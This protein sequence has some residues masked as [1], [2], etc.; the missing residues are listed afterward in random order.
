[1]SLNLLRL[2]PDTSGETK[3]ACPV[4]LIELGEEQAR[5]CTKNSLK[6]I[7]CFED[8]MIMAICLKSVSPGDCP[9][10]LYIHM[11]NYSFLYCIRWK[12]KA[13]ARIFQHLGADCLLDPSSV[14]SVHF[15]TSQDFWSFSIFHKAK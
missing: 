15:C 11:I 9:I 12:S 6:T 13:V 4:C 10:T 8:V 14:T 7:H 5:S 2:F 1:M 3:N